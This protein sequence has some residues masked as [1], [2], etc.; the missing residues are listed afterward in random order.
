M[1]KRFFIICAFLFAAM[2]GFCQ[3]DIDVYADKTNIDLSEE[4]QLTI[5]VKSSSTEV[6]VSQMPSL[7]NFNIYSS[8]QSRNISMINGKIKLGF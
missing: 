7:P 3:V 5:T 1:L 6:E 8:G 2:A 4:I